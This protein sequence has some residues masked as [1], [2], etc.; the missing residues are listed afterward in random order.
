MKIIFSNKI[1]SVSA[2]QQDPSFPV[3]NVLN[4]HSK[5][6]YKAGAHSAI[7]TASLGGGSNALAL[8]NIQADSLHVVVTGSDGSTTLLDETVDLTHDDGWGQYN[9]EAAF[10]S[11]AEDSATHTA[12]ITLSADSYDVALG[13]LFGGDALAFTNPCWG[14][15]D[16]A[17]SY[18]I[19][20]DLDN[21]FDHIFQ[22]NISKLENF[23]IQL[24]SE[25]EYFNFLHLA[26]AKYPLPFVMKLD[27]VLSNLEHNSIWYARMGG[28]PKGTRTKWG[29]YYISFSLKEFL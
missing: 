13:I 7:I 20:Y 12:T 5:K 17:K 4:S 11:Y 6:R 18:S 26:K 28:E 15:D 16:D 19:I 22:R 3:Q 27:H 23:K 25:T 1:E 14:M 9:A 24:F 21:G 10:F 2:D 29:N 8:Y